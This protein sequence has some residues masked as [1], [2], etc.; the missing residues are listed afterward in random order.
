[1]SS[2]CVC[3]SALVR[4]NMSVKHTQQEPSPRAVKIQE[5]HHKK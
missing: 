4:V 2:V 5:K 3:V 1:M